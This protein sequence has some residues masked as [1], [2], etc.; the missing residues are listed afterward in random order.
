MKKKLLAILAISFPLTAFATQE[1]SAGSALSE[2]EVQDSLDVITI[3]DIIKE[4][5][6]TTTRNSI[7]RHYSDVWARRSYFNLSFNKSHLQPKGDFQTGIG[8][9]IMGDVRSNWGIS[10]QY[11]RN[12]R[13]H[14]KPIGN[15]LQFYIDYTGID[16]SFSHYETA[17]DGKNIY[18]SSKL[19][20]VSDEDGSTDSYYYIPWNLEKYEGSYGMSIGPSMTLAPFT[21]TNSNGLHYLKFNMYFRIGYQA[22][23]LYMVNDKSAD[24]NQ[25]KGSTGYK[26]M[27]ENLKMNWGHG[28]L[29]SFGFSMTWKAI[30]IGYEH[31]VAHNRYK[32]FSPSDFG[33]DT[34]KFKTS[35]N[36]IYISFR[37]GR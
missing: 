25:G 29:T 31:R 26:E 19:Y 9:N 1:T 22:S 33:D 3:D 6:E 28:V 11:G 32:S 34:Y 10:L 15:V 8:D 12:Y 20:T 14:K 7:A 30:G 37:M 24:V 23:I 18:D 36:R 17:G 13:L 2:E 35:T 27:G 5:Q 21:Y 4:Q 16:L